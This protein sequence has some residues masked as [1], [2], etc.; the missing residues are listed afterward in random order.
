MTYMCFSRG[1]PTL[2]AA[3][4]I[5]AFFMIVPAS[6]S[7]AAPPG[8]DAPYPGADRVAEV[9]RLL[10]AIGYP[11]PAT[12]R[13]DNRTR[14]AV[15]YFQREHR[16]PV[17]GVVDQSLLS[18]IRNELRQLRAAAPETQGR[19]PEAA[20]IGV[21]GL[22]FLM[23]ALGTGFLARRRRHATGAA[24]ASPVALSEPASSSPWSGPPPLGQALLS[25]DVL[26]ERR[27]AHALEAQASGG[28]RLGEVLLAHGAIEA[29]QLKQV[30]AGHLGVPAVDPADEAIPLLRPS[31]A[32]ELGAV[33]LANRHD[34]SAVSV[35]FTSPDNE[36]VVAAEDHLG[37]P[38]RAKLSDPS[39]LEGLLAQAYGRT[40]ADE[41]SV[42]L[43]ERDLSPL[44]R[45]GLGGAPVLRAVRTEPPTSDAL[46]PTYSILV[47]IFREPPDR[48]ERLFAILGELEFPKQKLDGLCLVE[49]DDHPTR[50]VLTDIPPPPWMRVV[51]VPPGDRQGRERSLLYGLRQARGELVTVCD[52]KS[53]RPEDRLREA[54]HLLG[55]V[56][57]PGLSLN[58]RR[59][60]HAGSNE[61]LARAFLRAPSLQMHLRTD[62]LRR[63]LGWN[64]APSTWTGSDK[65]TKRDGTWAEDVKDFYRYEETYDW[66]AVADKLT[67]PE[68]FFHRSRARSVRR[69]VR[70]HG[71]FTK[72]VLDAGCGTGLNLRHLPEG[73]VGID[74]NPRHVEM[75]RD[76]LP[77]HSVIRGDIE[78]LPFDDSVFSMAV[79][80]EVLEH[81]PD[82]VAAL[83]EIRRVLRPGGT[84]VGSVPARSAIW[85]LRFLSR[86]HP[87]DEPFH[88]E[89]LPHEV[90]ALLK[91]FEVRGARRS[92]MGFNVFF[93]AR[94]DGS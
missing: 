64:A 70:R 63:S 34:S 91:G 22:I 67:G 65:P 45:R 59:S 88:N 66:V 4:L 47:P 12:G 94:K 62:D 60:Y 57:F 52:A 32:R 73:S 68:T 24:A 69:L 51:P 9:Q 13:F 82:P 18:E 84:L 42:A 76:R 20:A 58:G 55:L 26:D 53:K 41:A 50:A 83:A 48:L 6:A 23:S 17:D 16:L 29:E 38:V 11:L 81:V 28:G 14:G 92:L 1:K 56:E 27:L 33:A 49:A 35:A 2:S 93:V 7:A 80:T 86:S 74:L 87:G 46:L 61:Q 30:L 3:T 75:A 40:D 36:S 37:R 78:A 72:T 77:R 90:R 19:W 89:Y 8:F 25:A 71:D 85:K 43:M 39:T 44:P 15:T 21:A 79:C 5:V 31:T 10:R 54:A